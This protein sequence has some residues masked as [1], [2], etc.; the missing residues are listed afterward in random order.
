MPCILCPGG[1]QK[2]GA[3]V[4]TR[5][6]TSIIIYDESQ[7]KSI[8][9][10]SRLELEIA[11]K[12]IMLFHPLHNR[13][14]HHFSLVLLSLSQLIWYCLMSRPQLDVNRSMYCVWHWYQAHLLSIWAWHQEHQMSWPN[15]TFFYLK[16]RRYKIYVEFSF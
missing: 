2:K 4:K 1:F 10:Q 7:S 6:H 14:Q 15:L 13:I 5:L 9:V 11:L 8:E 16:V 3:G 12:R